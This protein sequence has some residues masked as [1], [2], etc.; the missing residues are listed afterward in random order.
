MFV[1][2]RSCGYL[3]LY[4]YLCLSL[5]QSLC[6]ESGCSDPAK[7]LV[8]AAGQPR[9]SVGYQTWVGGD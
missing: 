9:R 5:Y 2:G 4:H 8:G 7:A 1:L 3:Y 6:F